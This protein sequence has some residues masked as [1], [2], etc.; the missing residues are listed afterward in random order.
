MSV[1]IMSMIFEKYPNGGGEM[2]M[3]LA[4]ADHADDFG[5]NIYPSI[6]T[7]AKKTR[8][9]VRTVQYQLRKMT[10]AGFVSVVENNKGGRIKDKKYKSTEYRINM[11]FFDKGAKIAPLTKGCKEGDLRVQ[12]DAVKGA[13]AVAP[14]TSYK[15][16]YKPP[17]PATAQELCYPPTISK[18]ERKVI[19]GLIQRLNDKTKQEVLDELAGAISSASIKKGNIPFL[20]SLVDACAKKTFSPNLGVAVL[21]ARNARKLS[22]NSNLQNFEL[23][24][25]ACRAGEK[26]LALVRNQKAGIAEM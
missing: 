12:T 20:R 16:S 14:N 6:S 25:V 17:L 23:D 21:A 22:G 26:M 18:D 5:E 24:P 8:Q 9:S 4:L 1:K 19:D 3:A 11:G 15:P 10:D 7:L 2:L 13:I